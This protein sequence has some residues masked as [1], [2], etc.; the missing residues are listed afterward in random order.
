MRRKGKLSKA[1]ILI[2]VLL[3]IGFM[4]MEFPAIFFFKDVANPRIFGLPFT[5][6]YTI[7]LWAIMVVILFIADRINWG[8]LTEDQAKE[9]EK[10]K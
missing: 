8:S 1:G 9:E 2:R 5:Y 6:G 3:V 4:F 7:I 10:K